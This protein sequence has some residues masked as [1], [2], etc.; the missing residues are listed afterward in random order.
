MDAERKNNRRGEGWKIPSNQE[1]GV[2]HD[3]CACTTKLIVNP[4]EGWHWTIGTGGCGTSDSASYTFAR[5]M[6]PL[7]PLESPCGHWTIEQLAQGTEFD[8][9]FAQRRDQAFGSP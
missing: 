9:E 5:P 8:G 4:P 2:A 1:L 7:N 6:N 3:M